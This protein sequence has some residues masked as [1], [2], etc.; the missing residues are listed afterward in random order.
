MTRR[1]IHIHTAGDPIEQAQ[2]TH[3]TTKHHVLAVPARAT[4][5]THKELTAVAVLSRVRHRQRPSIV[6]QLKRLVLELAPRIRKATA[7][8]DA[9]TASA[10]ATHNVA[11]LDTLTRHDAMERRP[12]E[13]QSRA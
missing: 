9:L 3:H 2:T 12:L 10:I 11:A 5:Q 13:T 7:T 8:V 4:L 1:R 6:R